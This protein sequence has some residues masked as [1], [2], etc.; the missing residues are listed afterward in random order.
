[1]A[2]DH[3]KFQNVCND[4]SCAS[5]AGGLL[6]IGGYFFCKFAVEPIRDAIRNRKAAKE[7]AKEAATEAGKIDDQIVETTVFD[8][9]NLPDQEEA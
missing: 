1:M 3:A 7:A 9:E 5:M 4:V 2:F 6:A 8:Y